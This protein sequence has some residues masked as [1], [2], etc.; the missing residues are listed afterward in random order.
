KLAE[1]EAMVREAGAMQEKLFGHEHADV[2]ESLMHLADVLSSESRLV[3]AEAAYREA[4]AIQRKLFGNEHVE[5]SGSLNNLAKVLMAQGKLVEAEKMFRQALAMSQKLQPDHPYVAIQR[6][7]LEALLAA[8]KDSAGTEAPR[9]G[10]II[11]Q[12]ESRPTRPPTGRVYF[13]GGLA[14]VVN[15]RVI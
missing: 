1:A 10:A 12:K 6:S 2:A 8:R 5:I 7:N 13:P 11:A 3:E 14:A 9:Q 15:E 4:L